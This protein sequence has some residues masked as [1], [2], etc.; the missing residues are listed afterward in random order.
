MPNV[1]DSTLELIYQDIVNS[2][3]YKTT[4]GPVDKGKVSRRYAG[5]KT[6]VPSARLAKA[7]WR[8]AAILKP[9]VPPPAYIKLAPRAAYAEG[10]SDARFS[11]TTD[12]STLRPGVFKRPDGKYSDDSGAVY[13]NLDGLDESGRRSGAPAGVGAKQIDGRNL[14]DLPLIGDPQQNSGSWTV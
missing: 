3:G 13:T 10:G 2:V 4:V 8:V 7:A 9:I 11:L 12:G 6:E 1:P 5:Q 14:W